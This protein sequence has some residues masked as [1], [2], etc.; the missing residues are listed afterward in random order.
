MAK[1]WVDDEGLVTRVNARGHISRKHPSAVGYYP[2]HH[3]I[4]SDGGS[5]WDTTFEPDFDAADNAFP[6]VI[7]WLEGVAAAHVRGQRVTSVTITQVAREPLAECLASLIVR[8]PRMRYVAEKNVAEF[9]L[10][11][12]AFEKPHNVHQTAGSNLRRCQEPFARDI[13]TGGKFAFLLSETDQFAFGD[14]F[15]TNINPSPDRMLR[16]MVLVAIT[17]KIAV[18][19]FSPMQYP[20]YPEGVSIAVS[21]DEIGHFNDIVQIYAKDHLFYRGSMPTP[22][23]AFTDNQHYI[24][25]TEGCNHRASIV[26]GWQHEALRV[27]ESR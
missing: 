14:G 2:N 19:W 18:L 25:A 5:P 21:D 8:S 7:E 6:K 9:Q 17:P 4:L 10:Q 11:H 24:V 15:M 20:S 22:H 16:P 12:M 26:D 27:S 1:A 3:N 13:R 23:E